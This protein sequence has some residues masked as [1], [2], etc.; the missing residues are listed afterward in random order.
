MPSG[1]S[2]W[3]NVDPLR[4]SSNGSIGCQVIWRFVEVPETIELRASQCRLEKA[5]RA[6]S[7]PAR[8]RS[9]RAPGVAR[10]PPPCGRNP[11]RGAAG[12]T[13]QPGQQSRHRARRAR[14]RCS[15]G[16][17]QQCAERQE[18]EQRLGHGPGVQIDDEGV[19][20]EEHC[21]SQPHPRPCC[22]PPSEG[23]DPEGVQAGQQDHQPARRRRRH[24][25]RPAAARPA[26]ART[27]AGSA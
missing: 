22:Q 17:G 12:Q 13:G 23:A 19:Q 6:G 24:P 9:M 7:S 27:A 26:R 5:R 11:G 1:S 4:P 16:Q 18:Q 20:A 21:G 8:R 14:G 25:R 2:Q 10:A 15:P 3:A